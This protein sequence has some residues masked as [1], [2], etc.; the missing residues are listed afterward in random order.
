MELV[1]DAF[2]RADELDAAD[3]VGLGAQLVRQLPQLR[4]FELTKIGRAVDR[5]QQRRLAF[6]RHFPIPSPSRPPLDDEPSHIAQ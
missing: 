5:V 4:Y 2:E 1:G 6:F 3:G